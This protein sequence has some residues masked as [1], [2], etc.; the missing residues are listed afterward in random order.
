MNLIDPSGGQGALLDALVANAHN[1]FTDLLREAGRSSPGPGAADEIERQL[2]HELRA[3]LDTG[4]R[5]LGPDLTGSELGQ[6][7]EDRDAML[8]A[9]LRYQERHDVASM[10]LLFKR[11]CEHI[12][13]EE[14]SLL[15]S[16]GD[17]VGDRHLV[18]LGFRYA[19]V[20]DTRLD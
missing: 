12:E 11:F 7:R 17:R 4:A 13:L 5:V 18:A 15:S 8:A 2:D 19:E 14:L 6:L 20:A 3:H 1:R 10:R 16:V 9:L